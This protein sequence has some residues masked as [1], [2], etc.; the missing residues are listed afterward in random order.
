MIRVGIAEDQELVRSGFVALLNSADDIEVVAE[1]AD[2]LAGVDL[3]R[4]YRPDVLL[5]DIRMPHL[6]G[7]EATRRIVA[8]PVTAR[9]RVLILTTFD[10]DRYV[11]D[12]LR[13]GA[14]G[15]LLKDVT[16]ADLLTAVHVVAAG[17]ALLAPRITR[18]LIAH[19]TETPVPSAGS[20][21]LV[22]RLTPRERELLVAVAQGL[23]NAEISQQLFI[24]MATTKT[25]VSHLLEKLGA[26][27]RVQLT[28]LAYETGV[29][30]P[31]HGADVT[32]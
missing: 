6:D 31:G 9:T 21:E 2:G 20:L 29:V 7:V 24:S 15:F 11:H 8:E 14:S 26:R 25:H 3:A 5:M 23:S 17:E 16:A 10:A 12:A 13:A 18:R 32:R 30:R 1:A 22:S 4:R 27:D 19:F 28:I